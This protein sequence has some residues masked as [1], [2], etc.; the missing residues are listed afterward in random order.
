M[1]P[2]PQPLSTG[3]LSG[4]RHSVRKKLMLV[5]LATTFLALLL[6]GIAMMIY[7]LR[8][9]HDA[10]VGDLFTQADLI[11]HA[12]APALAF[13]DEKVARENLS[14]L[15]DL[16]KVSAAAIYTAKGARF[17]SY[18]RA[19]AGDTAFP[20]LPES[21]GYRVEGKELILFKRI[22]SNR[23]IVGMVY[24][25][26][27]YE[28][29]E[30]LRSYVAILAAVM[31]AS[32]VV[33]VLMTSWLQK[34]VTGPIL[35]MTDVARQ[36]MTRRDFS[37]RVDKST[38]DEVGYLVDTFNAMLA[39]I[40]GRTQALEASNRSLEQEMGERRSAEK[41]LLAADRQKDQFL[42][43][44]AHELRNPLAPLLNALQV[45]RLQGNDARASL[46]TRELMER[47]L[48]QLV[49]LVDDLL[50]VSRITTGKL[51]LR[52]EHQE[53]G[54]IVRTALEAVAPLMQGRKHQLDVS[55]PPEPVYLMADA[56]RLSQ[57]FVNLLNNA[58]KFTD[59]GGRIAF[60]ATA[61]ESE[62]TITVSDNGIGIP[63]AMLP[64]VFDMFAQADRSLERAHAGLGVGLS[65]ARQLVELHGGSIAGH[66]DGADRGSRFTVRLPCLPRSA[67][68][69]PTPATEARVETAGFRILLADDNVDFAESLSILLEAS[70]HEV[71]VTHDGIQALETAPGFKPDLCFLDIGLPRLHGYDLARRLREL[72]A[73]RGAYMVAISGWGQPE[74][75][76]RSR[77][78]GF[79]DHLAKPVEFDRIQELLDEFAAR[80]SAP[81]MAEKAPA[82]PPARV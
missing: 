37:L 62:V 39:E 45:L 14:L 17:A 60:S 35:A 46:A 11:G 10:R 22:E 47:Q 82:T 3:W 24:L 40:G 2:T 28:L 80:R 26:A 78:A 55:L 4:I 23:E 9:Y 65:L 13:D 74:D 75:K 27:S 6:M 54:A 56:T 67:A 19:E 76:R 41:A 44:L 20:A 52:K 29:M 32:L 69:L 12:S 58:A 7:D 5:V 70:G 8:A 72:P 15:K 61:D 53:L 66:S 42:A 49:Q 36:V 77:E 81:G 59:P 48:R 18:T 51:V 63:Q 31:A 34:S 79:D 71:A 57:V 43:T 1:T 50:D 25:K 38:D 16:P 33:A 64:L 30:R 21:E 73:T 68:A